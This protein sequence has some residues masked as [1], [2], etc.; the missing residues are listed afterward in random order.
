[1]NKGQV[2]LVDTNAIFEAFRTNC[3]VAMTTFFCVETVAEC[4]EE[5]R[6]GNSLRKGYVKVDD[7]P[8]RAGL[9]RIHKV[10]QL[11]RAKFALAFPRSY[12]L[13]LGERSLLAH[14]LGRTDTWLVVT[15]DRAAVY[16]TL[17]LGWRERIVSLEKVAHANGARPELQSQF[18]E[19]WLTGVC[20][21][22]AMQP[23]RVRK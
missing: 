20:T 13:D 10:T 9:K 8:L 7:K 18:C 14:A 22:W 23:R 16:A 21:D 12:G 2:V 1:V 17:D 11:E 19:K 6:T 4:E 3:W 15:A 5:A